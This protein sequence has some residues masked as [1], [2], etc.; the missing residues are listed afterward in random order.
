MKRTSDSAPPPLLAFGAH[1]DD[2]EFGCG[3]VIAV[4]ARRGRPVHFVIGS[5]GEAGTHGTPR[6]RT[7]EA[8]AAAAILGASVEF[9]ELGGDAHFEVR[10][11]HAIRIAEIIRR[12]RPA[13]VLAPSLVGNQHPDHARLGTMVRDAVRLARY[14]GLK[15]LRGAAPHAAGQLLFYAVTAEAEPQDMARLLIE[16]APAGAM[17]AWRAAMEAHAS[18]MKTRNYAELQLARARLNGMRAGV[19]FAIPLFA[20]DSP[21][22]DSLAPLE[23]SARRF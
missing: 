3:G 10:A 2:I 21:M 6:Q 1:P 4:E 13:I 14:G 15:E 8:R 20:A 23:R 7:R 19:E 16:V 17:A 11:V 9:I 12:R 18:Q 22:F 5:R